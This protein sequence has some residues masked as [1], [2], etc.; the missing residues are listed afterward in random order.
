MPRSRPPLIALNATVRTNSNAT[1]VATFSGR[2][3]AL[4]LVGQAFRG[5]N[6]GSCDGSAPSIHEQCDIATLYVKHVCEPLEALGATVEV[7]FTHPM[8]ETRELRHNLSKTLKGAYGHRVVA[9]RFVDSQG[10]GDGLAQAHNML[11]MHAVHQRLAKAKVRGYDFVLQTR[12]DLAVTKPLSQWP[13]DFSRLNFEQQCWVCCAGTFCQGACACGRD[14]QYIREHVRPSVDGNSS[15]VPDGCAAEMCV[16]DRMVWMP[17]RYYAL[18][19]QAIEAFRF[20]GILVHSMILAVLE[21]GQRVGRLTP[22]DLANGEVSFLFPPTAVDGEYDSLH[23][24]RESLRDRIRMTGTG[25]R[26]DA[27]GGRQMR[28]S[29]TQ[30]VRV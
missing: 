8:C 6:Q 4:L 10:H 28:K 15:C 30:R 25:R 18:V 27:R 20:D 11:T 17:W 22:S 29:Q 3:I 13:S 5:W 9:T 2:R 26:G 7:L 19:T 14:H 21:W 1:L 16:Q 12:H 23:M 24:R